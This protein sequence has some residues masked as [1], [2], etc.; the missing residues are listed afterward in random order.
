[1]ILA[2]VFCST[3]LGLGLHDGGLVGSGVHSDMVI[4]IRFPPLSL[5]PATNPLCQEQGR[6]CIKE[7]AR[8]P[9]AVDIIN[10]GLTSPILLHSITFSSLADLLPTNIEA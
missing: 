9:Q 8:A 10:A 2:L 6:E 4:K 1:M 3:V 7:E 5:H